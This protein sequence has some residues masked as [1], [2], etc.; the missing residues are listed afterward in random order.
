[1]F[2]HHLWCSKH[3]SNHKMLIA[4]LVHRLLRSKNEDLLIATGLTA[5]SQVAHFELPCLQ[6]WLIIDSNWRYKVQVKKGI[7]AKLNC[8]YEIINIEAEIRDANLD[9]IWSTKKNVQSAWDALLAGS[10]KSGKLFMQY[11]S[12]RKFNCFF[13]FF[14]LESTWFLQWWFKSQATSFL[15]FDRTLLPFFWCLTIKIEGEGQRW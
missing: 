4:N 2:V 5:M 3:F 15:L 12:S 14:Y 10:G 6:G 11:I 8:T 9:K 1:M 13:F 7:Q